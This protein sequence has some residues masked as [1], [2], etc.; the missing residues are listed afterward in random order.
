M[1]CCLL[2]R[3]DVVPKEN[4]PLDFLLQF[5]LPNMA[6]CLLYRGDVVPKE[7]FPLDFPLYFMFLITFI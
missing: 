4:Y 7:T 5:M 1:A 6:C 3:G 2:Y